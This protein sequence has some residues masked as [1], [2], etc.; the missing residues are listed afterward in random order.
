MSQFMHP[1][2]ND[3]PPATRE[4][5]IALLNQ[6]LADAIDLSLQAKQAHWNVKGPSFIALHKLFDEVA[7]AA[8]EGIDDLA[9]RITAL[10]GVADGTL[11]TVA[12]RTRVA[13]YP[14]EIVAGREHVAQ[15]SDALAAVGKSARAAI[16]E[17]DELGD[18]DTADLFTG[19]SRT[20]DKM[21]WF[22]EAHIQAT[23]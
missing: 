8:Q 5:V 23:E 19:I 10:G 6:N 20:L 4:K 13:P 22:V 3:L 14:T 15:L 7:E 18:K 9:E 12:K 16:D 17:S 2:R 21:L 1:T 11:Q